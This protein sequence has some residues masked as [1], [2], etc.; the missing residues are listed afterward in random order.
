MIPFAANALQ[1]IVDGQENPK[2]AP[3]P[4]DFVTLPEENRAIAIGNM[5]R[6]I[7]KDRGHARGS[8]DILATDRQTDRQTHTHHST[9]PL[10]LHAK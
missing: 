7:G 2:I 4:W 9:S 6:K 8:R 10:V 1:C 5:H 3:S